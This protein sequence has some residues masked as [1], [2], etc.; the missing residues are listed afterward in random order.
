MTKAELVE[1][2]AKSASLTKAAAEKAVGAFISTVTGALKKGDRVT[3]VG[4]GSFEV[5]SQESPHRQKS[6]DRQGN[7]DCRCQGSQVP[8]RQG[9]QGCGRQEE[10]TSAELVPLD[11]ML[12][13]VTFLERFHRKARHKPGF[14]IALP[15][16]RQHKSPTQH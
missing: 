5:A 16:P 4:F 3:L 14:F 13:G 15:V 7:Q 11:A 10:V 6:A 9:P 1:A 2:V 12:S 8:P